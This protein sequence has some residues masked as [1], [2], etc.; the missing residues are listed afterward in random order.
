M[1][2]KSALDEAIAVALRDG[3]R[4]HL[5]D[6]L[7]ELVAQHVPGA[8]VV[9]PPAEGDA[10]LDSVSDGNR[11]IGLPEMCRRLGLTR[12]SVVRREQ[13]GLIPRRLKWPDGRVGWKQADID[14]WMAQVEVAPDNSKANLER[15]ARVKGHMR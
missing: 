7:R 2:K 6:L 11:F 1:A 10:A 15:M 14:A 3:L 8:R 9:R 4:E 5:P 13:A 12:T